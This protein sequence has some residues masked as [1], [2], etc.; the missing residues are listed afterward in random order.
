MVLWFSLWFV[1]LPWSVGSVH[2][3]REGQISV[4]DELFLVF[5]ELRFKRVLH[6]ICI[7]AT[8][9]SVSIIF[10]LRS[11]LNQI[12]MYVL[13]WI[14]PYSTGCFNPWFVA[15]WWP[16]KASQV[17]PV[18]YFSKVD[19]FYLF[20]YIQFKRK[21]CVFSGLLFISSIS[22]CGSAMMAHT[23]TECNSQQKKSQHSTVVVLRLWSECWTL[24]LISIDKLLRYY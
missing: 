5:W 14:T 17:V 2:G 11:P 1:C 13:R 7:L 21:R 22:A 24:D 16:M 20:N 4:V 12:H 18:L 10:Y 23:H 6:Y 15:H 3:Q 8:A 9:Q 19:H